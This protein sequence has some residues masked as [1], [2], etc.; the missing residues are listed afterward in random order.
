MRYMRD[1]GPFDSDPGLTDF[2]G[3]RDYSSLCLAYNSGYY[4]NKTM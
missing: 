4:T 3:E 1:F 2:T